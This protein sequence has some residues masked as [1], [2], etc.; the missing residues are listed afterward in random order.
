MNSA[1]PMLHP[2]PPA[3]RLD[4]R[5]R[6]LPH[7]AGSELGVEKARNK[8]GFALFLGL[9][10]IRG[11]QIFDG[12]HNRTLEGESFD[13]LCSPVGPNFPARH[14]PDLLGV[15]LEEGFVEPVPETVPVKGIEVG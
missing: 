14:A 3:A 13:P 7:L 15:G 2:Y 12:M 1:H 10:K 5:G 6:L 9:R 4:L 8:T 11:E